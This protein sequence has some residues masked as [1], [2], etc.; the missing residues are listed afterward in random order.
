MG[1]ARALI[2]APDPA[3]LARR[4]ID[5]G[6][7][8]RDTEK[9]AR[10]AKP[11]AGGGERRDGGDADIVALERQLGDLLGLKVRINHGAKGGTLHLSYTT[12]DQLDMVCQRLSGEGI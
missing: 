4:V 2:G 10:A 3:L 6:L 12:L 8:V 5:E 1:H 7:S 11:R 9:L